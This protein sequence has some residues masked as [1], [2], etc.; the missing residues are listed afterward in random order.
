[1]PDCI[2]YPRSN[3]SD[4]F[5]PPGRFGKAERPGNPDDHWSVE[6]VGGPESRTTSIP[7]QAAG[8]GNRLGLSS[9][10]SLRN[11]L[12]FLGLCL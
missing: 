6:H 4:G 10:T 9:S 11:M 2:Q 7:C 8:S 12:H 5:D 1:M 3:P